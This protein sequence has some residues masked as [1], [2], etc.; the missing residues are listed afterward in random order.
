MRYPGLSNTA[1]PSQQ[2][3]YDYGYYQDLPLDR[4]VSMLEPCKTI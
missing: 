3:G 4:P 1:I 2:F